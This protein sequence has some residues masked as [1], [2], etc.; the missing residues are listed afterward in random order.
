MN[1]IVDLD[2]TL[3]KTDLLCEEILA[4]ISNNHTEI[5]PVLK[6]LLLNK[7]LELKNYLVTKQNV[8]IK[9]LPYNLEVINKIKFL[10]QKKNKIYLVTASPQK[11]AEKIGNHI[12]LFDGVYGSNENVNLKG[13]EKRDFLNQKFGKNNY[14]YF[15][16]SIDDIA[17]WKDSTRAYLVNSNKRI[18]NTIKKSNIPFEIIDNTSKNIKT[19]F[20]AIRIKQWIKNILIFIPMVAGQA[21]SQENVLL[22][23]F[24][25]LSFCFIAS[26]TYIFNDL[27]DIQADRD[28]YLKKNRMFASGTMQLETGFFLGIVSWTIGLII[29][30]QINF[31]FM[32]TLL[33]YLILTTLYSV[34]I[35]KI[36]IIDTYTLAILY[37]I[38]VWSGSVVIGID[39]SV[40]LF[41]LSIFLFYS[42][43]CVKRL[44]EIVNNEKS[45]VYT[46]KNRGYKNDDKSVIQSMAIAS[47][48]AATIVF[49]LY[50]N[51][52]EIKK[53][54]HYPEALW[55]IWLILLYWIN[56]II[57]MAQNGKINEDPVIFAIKNKISL[58]CGVL[59]LVLLIIGIM[60]E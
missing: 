20:S 8:D 53:F 60:Y 25:F 29:S 52:I 22:T 37:T 10:K 11:I 24:A 47:G 51:S 48:Y 18:K 15:G 43:A 17:V 40:W 45:R 4:T 30:L 55:G 5:L 33:L 3:V 23:T 28:H 39:L 35:K 41:A 46:I 32:M 57:F 21:Y 54:Y 56:Y 44:G 38:R 7:R 31:I 13:K 19:L 6:L 14:E 58:V 36:A 9:K 12:N 2:G 42:L 27:L 34:K 49:A 16:N 59:V 1:I 50:L 26:G